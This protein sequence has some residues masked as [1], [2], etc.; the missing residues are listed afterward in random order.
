MN[1]KNVLDKIKIALEC[2]TYIDIANAFADFFNVSLPLF[3]DDMNL[4][5]SSNEIKTCHQLI[6]L[7]VN[8]SDNELRV[9]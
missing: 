3:V 7:I 9:E 4:I 1:A 5:D 8:D 6:E 2:D